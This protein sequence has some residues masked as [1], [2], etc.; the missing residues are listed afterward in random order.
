M[1]TTHKR[2]RMIAGAAKAEHSV[3]RAAGEVRGKHPMR[4]GVRSCHL[5]SRIPFE[6][7]RSRYV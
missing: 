1:N 6:G 4:Q 7:W 2:K 5:V 3:P